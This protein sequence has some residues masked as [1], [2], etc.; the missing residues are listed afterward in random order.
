MHFLWLSS[1]SVAIALVLTLLHLVKNSCNLNC[2]TISS[3]NWRSLRNWVSFFFPTGVLCSCFSGY[4]LDDDGVTCLDI[5]ECETPSSCSQQCFNNRGS[6]VCKCVEGYKLESDS[7]RCKAVGKYYHVTCFYVTNF[8]TNHDLVASVFR[9]CSLPR[10]LAL[11]CQDLSKKHA[12]LVLFHSRPQCSSY[13]RV[14]GRALRLCACTNSQ[15][16][17][18]YS[19]VFCCV[20]RTLAKLLPFKILRWVAKRCDKVN[21]CTNRYPMHQ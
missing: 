5:D 19:I 20:Q 2:V 10:L 12:E 17:P 4:S 8:S 18:L 21:P 14:E 7:K 9:A 1:L 15:V 11:N 3:T 13:F 16:S 6:F